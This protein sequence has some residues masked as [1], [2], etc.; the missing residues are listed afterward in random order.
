[1]LSYSARD[2][3]AERSMHTGPSSE[4]KK[5]RLQ[6]ALSKVQDLVA[7]QAEGQ[8][9]VDNTLAFG[10][11]CLRNTRSDGRDKINELMKETQ[12]EWEKLMKKLVATKISLE[13]ALLQWSDYNTSYSQVS[14]LISDR[15]AKLQKISEHKPQRDRKCHPTPGTFTIADFRQA[16]RVILIVLNRHCRNGIGINR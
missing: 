2:A 5:Q 11:K 4:D 12:N 7:R 3:I 1:M 10:E 8:G 14:Q 9:Y 6:S 15:E 16:G 13:T